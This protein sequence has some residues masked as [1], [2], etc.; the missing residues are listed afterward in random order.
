MT[1]ILL[2]IIIV[3]IAMGAASFLERSSKDS[4]STGRS[5]F[6]AGRQKSKLLEKALSSR[7]TFLIAA[8]IIAMLIFGVIPWPLVVRGLISAAIFLI[9]IWVINRVILQSTSSSHYR[10]QAK[11]RP[12]NVLKNQSPYQVL[13]IK[14]TASKEEVAKAYRKMAKKYH[15]DIVADLAPEFRELAEKRMKAINAAYEQLNRNF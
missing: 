6:K 4:D 3:V 8:I 5:D 1:A 12:Q 9:P 15:P 10:T 11:T 7:I 13:D 14:P 2:I